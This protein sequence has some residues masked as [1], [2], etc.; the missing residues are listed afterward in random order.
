MVLL[1]AIAIGGVGI[2]V[3]MVSVIN[4]AKLHIFLQKFDE[5]VLPVFLFGFFPLFEYSLLI[6]S[7]LERAC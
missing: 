7:V 2:P 1:G 4:L 6:V 3:I 5:E